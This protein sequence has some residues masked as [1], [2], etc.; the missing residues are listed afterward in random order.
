MDLKITWKAGENDWR[1]F[2]VSD[3][4]HLSRSHAIHL[5]SL[6]IP[7]IAKC[8]GVYFVNRES[9]AASYRAKGQRVK[10]FS[11]LAPDERALEICGFL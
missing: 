3:I 6:G 9:L 11:D 7:V 8:N 10:L 2:D 5:F 4:N 1:E